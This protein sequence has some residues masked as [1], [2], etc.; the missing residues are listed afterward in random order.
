MRSGPGASNKLIG[1]IKRGATVNIR[2]TDH[3]GDDLWMLVDVGRKSGWVA[4]R[5]IDLR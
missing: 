2:S 4:G 5:Y 3:N 1:A